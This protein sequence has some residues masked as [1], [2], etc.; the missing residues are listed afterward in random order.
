MTG[1]VVR[2]PGDGGAVDDDDEFDEFEDD[3][4]ND[5]NLD[6]DNVYRFICEKPGAT[7]EA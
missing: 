7:I 5:D 2:Q 1:I 4:D 3:D 6:Q